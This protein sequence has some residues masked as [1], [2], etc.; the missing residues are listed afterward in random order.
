MIIKC[1]NMVN[2]HDWLLQ[3]LGQLNL[4][5]CFHVSPYL[6]VYIKASIGFTFEQYQ[7]T[8]IRISRTRKKERERDLGNGNQR[9]AMASKPGPLSRWPWQDHGNYK[10]RTYSTRAI[11][12]ILLVYTI[13]VEMVFV[14]AR[15]NQ[16]HTNERKYALLAPWAAHC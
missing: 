5:T 1:D 4:R 13:S 7:T 2:L 12:Q 10:V 9:T 8:Q 3:I 6:G 16:H 11:V 14:H 15:T